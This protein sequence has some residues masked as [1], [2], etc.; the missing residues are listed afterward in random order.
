MKVKLVPEQIVPLFMLMLGVAKTV[1]VIALTAL[2]TFV[3]VAE[4]VYVVFTVGLTVMKVAF[5]L[6]ASQV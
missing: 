5:E 4:T 3:P 6:G 2:Q 1:S